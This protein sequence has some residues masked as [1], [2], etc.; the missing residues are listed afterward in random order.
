MFA[1]DQQPVDGSGAEERPVAAVRVALFT[2]EQQQVAAAALQHLL[3]SGE[4]VHE[5]QVGEHMVFGVQLRRHQKPDHSGAA[6][7]KPL[8]VHIGDV[9]QL[10]RGGEHPLA[11]RLRNFGAGAPVEHL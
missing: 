11:G 6:A 5:M 10:P 2:E 7:E 8:G 4:D 1:P 9:I 3:H